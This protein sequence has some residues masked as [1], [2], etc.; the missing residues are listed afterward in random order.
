MIIVN[1]KQH[2]TIDDGARDLGVSPKTLRKY[3]NDGIVSKPPTVNQGI[4]VYEVFP[5]DYIR[6]ARAEIDAYRKKMH[7]GDDGR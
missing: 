4:R 5:A 6:R 7:G 2:N 3:I 1:G